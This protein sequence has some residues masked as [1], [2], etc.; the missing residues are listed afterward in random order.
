MKSR[1]KALRKSLKL[2]QQEFA[3]RIGIKRNTVGLYEI[4]QSGVSDTVIKSI[5]REFN[6]NEAWLRT[7]EGEM[8]K[9]RSDAEI[10]ADFA[11]GLSFGGNESFK[12]RLVTAI[13]QMDDESWDHF[14]KWLSA[15][16]EKYNK[17]LP[18]A[19]VVDPDKEAEEYRKEL[20]VQRDTG[21][22]SKVLDGTEEEG[23]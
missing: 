6:V 20:I 22:K 21:G 7:G 11:N 9:K 12:K 19:A 23:A 8:F 15:F 5:C 3:D 14:E 16:L 10:I 1:I 2:T 13:A 17:P 4:G 18:D